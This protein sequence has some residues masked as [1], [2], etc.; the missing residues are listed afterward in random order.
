MTKRTK[1]P[2]M[3][4]E[5]IQKIIE[6][7][8]IS[9]FLKKDK[10][11]S[12]FLIAPPEQSKSHFIL[13]KTTRFSHQASDLSFMGLVKILTEKKALKHIIIPDFLKITEK[14]QTTKNNL[15]TLL[16]SFLEE[17]IFEINLGN[18]E[19]I[20]LEGKQGGIITATTDYSFY[21]N[22]KNWGGI[23]FISRFIVVSYRY[24]QETID[25]ILRLIN[26]EK[27]TAKK[28]PIKLTYKMTDVQSSEEINSLLNEYNE[29]SLR[30]QK[31]LI[32]LLKCIALRNHRDKT[33][34]EDVEELKKLIPFLNTRFT[35]I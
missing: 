10:P 9:G 26:K 17:G 1:T 24:K 29:G 2:T 14:K 33:N 12:L 21:Q 15:L 28:K 16:N 8:Y 18:K 13:E 3:K 31:N 34:K 5:D 19:K 20:D 23:G 25:E 11:L 4:K 30:R 22:R 27:S 7:V 32:V 35:R 6:L